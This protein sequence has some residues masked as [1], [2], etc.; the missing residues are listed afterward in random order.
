MSA[1][2]TTSSVSGSFDLDSVDLTERSLFRDGFPHPVFDHLRRMAPVWWHPAKPGCE[3]TSGKG[4]WVLSRQA[5]VVEA[6]RD[7]TRF[8]AKDGP[9]L[10]ELGMSGLPMLVNME[11]TPHIR[12]R[13]LISAGFTPR[14]IG[15]LEQQAR[16]WAVSI[17]EEALERGTVDFV[18]R[19]AY[20]LPM[21]MIADI[22]GIPVEDREW[23]FSLANDMLQSSDPEHGIPEEE[24]P[25]ITA[26]MYEYGHQLSE[27]KRAQPQDDVWTLLTDVEVTDDNGATLKLS[28]IELDG[29]FILLTGAG[30]ETTRNAISHGLQALLADEAQLEQLR[31]N[32]GLLK[33]ATEEIIRW[34]SPVSYFRRTVLRDTEIGGVTVAEGDRVSLWYPSA[35]RDERA[36]DDPYRFDVSRKQNEQVSFGGGGAHFCLGAHLARREIMILFEELLARVGKIEPLGPP[37]YS[38]Q[39]IGNPLVVSLKHLPV[40]MS[41]R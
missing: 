4:F 40:H 23:L 33:T 11:G 36:F 1:A 14:M 41:A 19:V 18:D 7:A 20:Q 12:Q 24:R 10:A 3:G 22:M 21:H 28:P 9:S 6:S 31:S 26:K 15:R 32:P 25:A 37:S 39:G 8:S 17:I 27:A 35:N 2:E 34:A 13:K 38:V 29:F 16:G 30:S 5:D